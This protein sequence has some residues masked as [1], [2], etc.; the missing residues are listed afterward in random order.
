MFIVTIPYSVACQT[1]CETRARLPSVIWHHSLC[2]ETD[3]CT[4]SEVINSKTFLSATSWS[5]IYI[6]PHVLGK[7]EKN[8]K[9]PLFIE[10]C[11]CV[12][13]KIVKIFKYCQKGFCIFE[14]FDMKAEHDNNDK[15]L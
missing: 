8:F 6:A 1:L 14:T 15:R 2:E 4:G 10:Y 9:A 13:V 7:F 11:N 5:L 3:K 12:Y